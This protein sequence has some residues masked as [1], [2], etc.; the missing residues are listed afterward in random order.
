LTFGTWLNNQHK[1]RKP[2]IWVGVAA[3]CWAIWNCRNDIVFKKT[4]FNSIL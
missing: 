2:L 3:I 4:K 1:D